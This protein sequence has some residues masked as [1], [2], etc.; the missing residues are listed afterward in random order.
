MGFFSKAKTVSDV[1]S[2]SDIKQV[3]QIFKEVED[4]LNAMRSFAV[5]VSKQSHKLNYPLDRSLARDIGE[6]L[7]SLKLIDT[8]GRRLEWGPMRKLKSIKGKFERGSTAREE[9][10]SLVKKLSYYV[11]SARVAAKNAVTILENASNHT[12]MGNEWRKSE[13]KWDNNI[14]IL[15][16]DLANAF[17]RVSDCMKYTTSQRNIKRSPFHLW[18]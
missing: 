10:P 8:Q 16:D 18:V 14:R 12:Q 3:L 1:N 2:D 9:V 11:S 5:F 6:M 4:E 13:A 15:F 17:G 7:H